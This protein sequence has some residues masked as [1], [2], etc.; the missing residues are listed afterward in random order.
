MGCLLRVNEEHFASSTVVI[1]FRAV[2]FSSVLLPAENCTTLFSNTVMKKAINSIVWG[3]MMLTTSSQHSPRDRENKINNLGQNHKSL[4]FLISFHK[5]KAECCSLYLPTIAHG[6][7]DSTL[8]RELGD[9][10]S[11]SSSDTLAA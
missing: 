10:C 6:P 5:R 1:L 7:V 2:A 11:S 8:C 9:F 4:E 3:V